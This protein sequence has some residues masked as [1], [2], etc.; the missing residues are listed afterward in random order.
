MTSSRRPGSSRSSSRTSGWT[1]REAYSDRFMR[2]H[3][4]AIVRILGTRT[5]PTSNSATCAQSRTAETDTSATSSSTK[6]KNG[7]RKGS[8]QARKKGTKK[9]RKKE[10]KKEPMDRWMGGWMDG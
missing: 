5:G 6:R 8:K 7:E 1:M 3:S 2:P 10:R 9:E 4:N